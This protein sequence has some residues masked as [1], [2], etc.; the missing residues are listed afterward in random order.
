LFAVGILDFKHP[1]RFGSFPQKNRRDAELID[2]FRQKG[3]P[4]N[5]ILYLQDKQA[6]QTRIQAA[7]K[8]QLA[9]LGKDD[10]LIVYYAGHGSKADK[11]RDVYLV[12]YDTGDPHVNGWSVKSIPETINSYPSC[13]KVLWLID[14]CYSGFAADTVASRDTGA[15]FA[16]VTSSSASEISTGHWTFTEAILDAL[17]GQSYVD[18]NHNGAITLAELASHAERDMSLAEEQLS[19]SAMSNGFDPNMVLAKA[20]AL[21]NVRIGERDKIEWQGDWYPVRVVALKGN[22]L[23]VHYIGYADDEDIWTTPDKLQPIRPKQFAT[24]HKV[25][26][27][28]KKKWFPATVLKVKEGIHFIHYTDYDSSWD[29]WVASKRIRETK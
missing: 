5:Q 11:G 10:L 18:L 6:T 12:S 16:C 22:Q 29:E 7:F 24:G 26:V 28:W 1:D 4:P 21:E 23:K 3:V 20:P 9:Q 2:F 17:R 13:R 25:D 14:C 19:V 27:L 8:E 15:A